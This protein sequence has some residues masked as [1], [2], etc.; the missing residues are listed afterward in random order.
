MVY[1]LLSKILSFNKMVGTKLA[2]IATSIPINNKG[3]I[4]GQPENSL[5]KVNAMTMRGGKSTRDPP[6]PNNKT[7]KAQGQ[8]EERPPPI[9]KNTKRSWRSG[10]NGTRGLC[11]HH[12]LVVPHEKKKAGRGRVICSFC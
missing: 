3:K 1:L 6:N 7:G 4:L 2:Q 8:Q 12:I 9:N 11:G 5:E 10:G